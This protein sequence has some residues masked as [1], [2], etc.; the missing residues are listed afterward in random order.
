MSFKNF[1]SKAEKSLYRIKIMKKS[2]TSVSKREFFPDYSW[3]RF[4]EGVV[5]VC[6]PELHLPIVLPVPLL[7]IAKASL[8]Q[9]NALENPVTAPPG[10][11]LQSISVFYAGSN[12][13][14]ADRVN[15][16]PEARA[17]TFHTAQLP[18]GSHVTCEGPCAHPH[19][20]FRQHASCGSP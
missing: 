20:R 3:K 6:N 10:S 9:G 11:N 5:T 1:T 12:A 17:G 4:L 8:K 14:E 15:G 2:K 18:L 19:H 7:K 16:G 13:Y